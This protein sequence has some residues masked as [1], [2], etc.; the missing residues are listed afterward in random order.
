VGAI[1]RAAPQYLAASEL[2]VRE[3][4][5]DL[6]PCSPDALPYVEQSARCDN[7]IVATGHAMIAVSLAR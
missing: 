4:W 1:A 6:R 5:R 7:V 3:I 2:R